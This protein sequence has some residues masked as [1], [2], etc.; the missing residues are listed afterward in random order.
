MGSPG[1]RAVLR[2]WPFRLG[3]RSRAR[4]DC[5][6]AF[7]T[8]T[9]SSDAAH[10]L[11]GRITETRFAQALAS[12][13]RIPLNGLSPQRARR[14]PFKVARRLRIAATY[15][16]ATGPIEFPGTSRLRR[17]PGLSAASLKSIILSVLISYVRF[18]H[19]TAEQ[20]QSAASDERCHPL[21]P[22]VRPAEHDVNAVPGHQRPPANPQ[23]SGFNGRIPAMSRLRR[24]RSGNIDSA[25]P[26]EGAMRGRL[27]RP[28]VPP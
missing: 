6:S 20:P 27:L 5:A 8:Q 15:E 9:N 24:H 25:P 28:G 16:I 1:S 19:I 7:E 17:T 10:N 14:E 21:I 12:R 3:S 11:P 23:A 26:A 18:S 4:S 13:Q 22:Y 2:S